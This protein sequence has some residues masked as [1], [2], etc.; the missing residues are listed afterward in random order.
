MLI[1]K[2]RDFFVIPIKHICDAIL[3]FTLIEKRSRPLAKTSLSRR[4]PIYYSGPPRNSSLSMKVKRF[5][6]KAVLRCKGGDISAVVASAS[7][8]PR[9]SESLV[10]VS[11]RTVR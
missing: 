10:K 8:R 3:C 4:R 11:S 7:R 9:T 1:I 6:F 2:L 5:A